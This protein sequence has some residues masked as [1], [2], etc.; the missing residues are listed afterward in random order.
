MTSCYKMKI[1][2]VIMVA[3]LVTGLVVT[4][5]A[6]DQCDNQLNSCLFGMISSLS[7]PVNSEET[8]L[9]F[10]RSTSVDELC[11]V[12]AGGRNCVQ[13]AL[14][15]SCA[16][17][18]VHGAV[19]AY[20][21]VATYACSPEGRQMMETAQKSPCLYDMSLYGELRTE[22]I[23]CTS[24]G[25]EAVLSLNPDHVEDAETPADPEMVCPIIEGIENCI[26]TNVSRVCG[27]GL[28]QLMGNVIAVMGPP[29]YRVNCAERRRRE[30][31]FASK[32]LGR[33]L[34]L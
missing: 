31:F 19:H 7:M 24:R 10:V 29:R 27:A 16:T 2:Q 17:Q 12:I 23:A 28:G 30:S 3:V 20:M 9:A 4:T 13:H 5:N 22:E 32:T 8:F 14:D 15:S 6:D 25:H 34:G 1:F 26:T 33:L 18:N 11:R 21:D